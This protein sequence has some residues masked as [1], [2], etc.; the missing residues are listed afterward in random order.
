MRGYVVNAVLNTLSPS[1]D[2]DAIRRT[3]A[4]FLIYPLQPSYNSQTIV[5]RF[6]F[7]LKVD[8]IRIIMK[9]FNR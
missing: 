3:V 5:I 7:K 8:N 9:L 6:F 4:S 1:P 2:T